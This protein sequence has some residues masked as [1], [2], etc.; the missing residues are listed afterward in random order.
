MAHEAEVDE[1]GAHGHLLG[2]EGVPVVPSIEL[3]ILVQQRGPLDVILFVIDLVCL[4]LWRRNI[5]PGTENSLVKLRL[6][7]SHINRRR[8]LDRLK[9]E[10]SSGGST[11]QRALKRALMRRSIL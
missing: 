1:A 3:L 10:R 5:L 7:L 11:S 8:V 9:N 6:R 2:A 4:I